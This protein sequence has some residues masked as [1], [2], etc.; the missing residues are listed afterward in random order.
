MSGATPRSVHIDSGIDFAQ[1]QKEL[2]CSPIF[3]VVPDNCVVPAQADTYYIT[4]L[5]CPSPFTA[6]GRLLALLGDTKDCAGNYIASTLWYTHGL[7]SVLVISPD[8]NSGSVVKTHLNSSFTAHETWKV[9]ASILQ[10]ADNGTALPQEAVSL[11]LPDYSNL[12]V[13]LQT[14]LDEFSTSLHTALSRCSVYGKDYLPVFQGI[15]ELGVKLIDELLYI[16]RLAAET[17]PNRQEKAAATKL[18][19]I[20]QVYNRARSEIVQLN[21]ALAYTIS[22]WFS[23]CVP[24]LEHE[25]QV[26][27]ESLLGLGTAARGVMGILYRV[28]QIFEKHGIDRVIASSFYDTVANGFDVGKNNFG[29][30]TSWNDFGVDRIREVPQGKG[31]HILINFSARR[32]FRES[33]HC[34]TIPLDVLYHGAS[35]G[36]SLMT[37]SHEIVHAHVRGLLAAIFAQ[38][39]SSKDVIRAIDFKAIANDYKEFGL[40]RTPSIRRCMQMCL[41]HYCVLHEAA[42]NVSSARSGSLTVSS[43]VSG[44]QWRDVYSP[45]P[46]DMVRYYIDRQHLINEIIVHVLDFLYF[47]DSQQDLYIRSLWLSWCQVPVVLEHVKDYVLRTICAISS[48]D[49]SPDRNIRFKTAKETLVQTLQQ[50]DNDHPHPVLAAALQILSREADSQKMKQIFHA[51]VYLVDFAKQL[52][53]STSLHG[54]LFDDYRRDTTRTPKYELESL[55]F[56][57]QPVQS[58]IAFVQGI[59]ES[60]VYTGSLPQ[61]QLMLTAW[62][63]VVCA[64]LEIAN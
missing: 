57:T 7:A 56:Q 2:R 58:P 1:P 53:H 20:Q 26:R 24:I 49:T 5:F 43:N 64:S 21:A 32:G 6:L 3:P 30:Q 14:E 12:S 28:E 47:Y 18:L 61:D 22:Q 34:I 37:I 48:V 35:P 36:W 41:F 63:L 29:L 11:T 23:G 31:R 13:E 59:L 46:D 33:P 38:S 8:Q 40:S 25:C 17:Q 4:F 55:M 15:E 62:M 50:I 16:D 52:L 42:E 54:E 51:N 27:Q 44:D 19:E 10:S 9:S 39:H 60:A 45:S